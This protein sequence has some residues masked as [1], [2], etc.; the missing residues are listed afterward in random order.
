MLH[1]FSL[2]S[3]CDLLGYD[4]VTGALKVVDFSHSV[5]LRL[6]SQVSLPNNFPISQTPHGQ[7]LLAK[8]SLPYQVSLFGRIP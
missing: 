8:S 6:Q 1:L 2:L 3:I 7:Q 4:K 5:D